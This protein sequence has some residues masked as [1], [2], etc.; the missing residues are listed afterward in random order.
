[1]MHE[2]MGPTTFHLIASLTIAV[3]IGSEASSSKSGRRP[4]STTASISSWA[5]LSMSG[6]LSRP[7]MQVAMTATV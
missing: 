7:R 2:Q 1:M 5:F 3:I 4:D 6:R